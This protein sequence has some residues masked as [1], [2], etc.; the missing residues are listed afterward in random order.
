MLKS[1]LIVSLVALGLVV[2]LFSFPRGII[3]NDRKQSP[4]KSTEEAQKPAQVP[5][6]HLQ[7]LDADKLAKLNNW[8][9]ELTESTHIDRKTMLVDSLANLYVS[10][11][12]PD[13]AA[14]F[15]AQIADLNPG[16][17]SLLRAGDAYYEAFRF[18]VDTKKAGQM[19]E[20]A[21]FFYQKLLAKDPAQLDAK[22]RMAM[23]YVAEADPAQGVMK[24]VGILK[25]VLAESP[26]NQLA[27][28]SLGL[29]SLQSKQFDKAA[30]R[31]KQILAKHPE[32]SEARLYLG[33]SYMNMN[34]VEEARR[35]FEVIV[36]K[37][38]DPALKQEA[39]KY[40]KQLGQ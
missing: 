9:Q 22:S 19:G 28:F 25:E 1:Q 13:S 30:D 18:A 11:S 16:T 36:K 24:G 3:R 2:T 20:K 38:P 34:L 35:E 7:D 23:T 17:A 32:N 6:N 27:L 10:I 33:F 5:D 8:K 15:L 37:E 39:E 4:A 12:K 40:L 14:F 29:L 21:R 26:D 31:F